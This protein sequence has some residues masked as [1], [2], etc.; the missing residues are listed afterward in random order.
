MSAYGLPAMMRVSCLRFCLHAWAYLFTY[1][2]Y[3]YASERAPW[4]YAYLR[5]L[6]GAQV[7]WPLFWL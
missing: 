5:Y 1:L 3:S 6:E 7:F 2:A 4:F